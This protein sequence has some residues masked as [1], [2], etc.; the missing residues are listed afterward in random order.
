MTEALGE[1]RSRRVKT[2]KP[3][4][5]DK[6]LGVEGNSN[7]DGA[8]LTTA[9]K[10]GSSSSFD[11]VFQPGHRLGEKQVAKSPSRSTGRR[12]SLASLS[13]IADCRE[14]L[15]ELRWQPLTTQP[16]PEQMELGRLRDAVSFNGSALFAVPRKPAEL[17]QGA[18]SAGITGPAGS[19]TVVRT[20]TTITAT[21]KSAYLCCGCVGS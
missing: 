5:F 21:A 11:Q 18:P 10:R 2:F 4:S 19:P 13:E 6:L 12:S 17:R 7:E 14:E 9:S 3:S 1:G 8:Y 20:S 15:P 16:E